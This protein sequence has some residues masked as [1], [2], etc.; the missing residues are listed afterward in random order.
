MRRG[1]RWLP[2]LPPAA[3][4]APLALTL[5]FTL[6]WAA[7][8]ELD[9]LPVPDREF[10]AFLR[11]EGGG[12]PPSPG[13][14]EEP[15]VLLDWHQAR[16]YCAAQGKRLPTAPEWLE[17]C[18]AKRLEF[19]SPIWEWTTTETDRHGEDAKVRFKLLCG[20][21]PECS[22]THAYHPN[23][24]NEV[25]GFRCARGLPSVRLAPGSSGRF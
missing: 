25:K 13:G 20:P 19:Q 18:R 14:G 3:A 10:S 12:R 15:A 7:G 21:G 5:A 17:A 1:I 8:A 23:W 24:R 4:L 2:G 6:A 11:R 22:C 9:R 16:A